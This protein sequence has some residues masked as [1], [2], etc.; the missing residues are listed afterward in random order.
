MWRVCRVWCVSLLALPLLNCASIYEMSL[1]PGEGVPVER[2]FKALRCEVVTFLELNRFRREAFEK[3]KNHLGYEAAYAKYAYL[4]LEDGRYGALQVDLKTIDSLGLT[5]GVDWKVLPQPAGRSETWHIGPSLS[6]NKTYTRTTTFA[7]PQDAL[8][9]PSLR[10]ND[11]V[12]QLSV[13]DTRSDRD[14]FCFVEAANLA[15]LRASLENLQA[16][17]AHQIP[18]IEN[19]D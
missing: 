4:N 2:V 12:D 15:P 9:G 16:L 14:F 17:A 11:A 18:A 13:S 1:D 3:Q 5:V 6:A 8:L 7:I 19:F 10:E